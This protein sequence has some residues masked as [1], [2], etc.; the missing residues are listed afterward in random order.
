MKRTARR[1]YVE[2]FEA[3]DLA[4][5]IYHSRQLPRTRYN[6]QDFLE[7]VTTMAWDDP[8]ATMLDD[9]DTA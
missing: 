4:A 9:Y 2:K 8:E 6:S 5:G 3:L 7:Y 1:R